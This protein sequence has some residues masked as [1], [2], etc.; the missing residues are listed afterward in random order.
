MN[1]LNRLVDGT[2]QLAYLT[3]AGID[4]LL[5]LGGLLFGCMHF[6]RG[7]LGIFRDILHAVGHLVDCRGHQLHLL[8]LLLAVLLGFAGNCAE[9]ASGLIQRTCR[10]E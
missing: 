4:I 7:V 1:H 6:S 9:R 5:A 10:F 2:G 8:R 3:Q